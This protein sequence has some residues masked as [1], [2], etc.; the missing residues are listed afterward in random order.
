MQTTPKGIVNKPAP[1]LSG[2]Q[3]IG[4]AAE[5]TEGEVTYMFFFQSWCPGCHSHGFP[6]LKSLEAEFKD[7]V[8]FIAVQTVFEGFSTNTKSRAARV[9]KSFGLDIPVGHDGSQGKPSKLLRRYRGGGTPWTIIIDRNGVVRFNGFRLQPS[10]GKEMLAMLINEPVYETIPPERGGQDLLGTK[11]K[12]PSFGNFSAPLTLYRWW[13]DTCAYCEASLPALDSLREKYEV[14]GLRVVG[15][16]HPKPQ[17]R[18][19]SD[20]FVHQGAKDRSFKGD[21]VI[22][23]NWSQLNKWWLDTGNR[24]ATSVS[25]LVDDKG[26][27][28]FVHPGPVLFPSDEKK[29]SQENNDFLLLDKA[30]DALLPPIEP[31]EDKDNSD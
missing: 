14:R 27:V 5:I 13:T 15:V 19:V 1:P 16:Y 31:A 6:T 22:D 30:I 4:D 28:R 17:T 3:W 18:P 24:S 7:D 11:L 29:F 12:Q 10:Q 21:V 25:I 8:N 26:I 23:S 2:V 20:E 9:V